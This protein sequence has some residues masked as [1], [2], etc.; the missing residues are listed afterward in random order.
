MFVCVCTHTHTHIY[1]YIYIYIHWLYIVV[2]R[3]CTH[4][5]TQTYTHTNSHVYIYIYIYIP[6]VIVSFRYFYPYFHHHFPTK[7]Y[8]Y[9]NQKIKEKKKIV[10][11]V[12]WKRIERYFI[13]MTILF[14]FCNLISKWPF[15]SHGIC[16]SFLFKGQ[17]WY[18]WTHS[19][20][21]YAFKFSPKVK[22]N[23]DIRDLSGPEKKYLISGFGLFFLGNTGSKLRPDKIYL[24]HGF[25]LYQ[26]IL[27]PGY[28]VLVK[29]I[30]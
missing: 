12:L 14:D 8:G 17:Y 21:A 22:C 25:L 24:I 20:Y 4:T 1:I 9:R 29:K 16:Q 11:D 23:T 27:Y 10:W 30:M 2:Q 26:G 5:H 7:I 18:N 6:D 3:A 19:R 15:K 13:F 28:T